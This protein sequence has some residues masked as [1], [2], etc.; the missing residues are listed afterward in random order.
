LLDEVG[1]TTTDCPG[2]L[3]EGKEYYLVV[4]AFNDY[5]ESGNSNEVIVDLG[6]PNTSGHIPAKNATDI[7][8]DTNIVV[9]VQDSVDGVDQS[10]IVMRVDGETVQPLISGSSADYTLTYDPPMDFKTQVLV[11]ILKYLVTL[12]EQITQEP[13]R[14]LLSILMT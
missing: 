4:R 10:S 5:G 8:P 11:R 3:N 7:S 14:I 13:Y 2:T 6:S 1:G 12:L 9:H